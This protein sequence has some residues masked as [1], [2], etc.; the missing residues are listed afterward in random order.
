VSQYSLVATTNSMVQHAGPLQPVDRLR[1]C[2]RA[3]A[4]PGARPLLEALDAI[5]SRRRPATPAPERQ[6]ARHGRR[7]IHEDH[8]R[9]TA[10]PGRR[11]R[12]TGRRL[13]SGLPRRGRQS[14]RAAAPGRRQRESFDGTWG[15]VARIE[16]LLELGRRTP[17][18]SDARG[19]PDFSLPRGVA[20]ITDFD[21]RLGMAVLDLVT[22]SCIAKTGCDPRLGK[23]WRS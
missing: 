13:P 8:P 22:Q 2:L 18:C 4:S 19:W 23:D 16:E 17:A 1:R 3:S 15:R 21:P 9:A 7:A 12:R 6:E 14:P 5:A 10:R 11:A 20:A